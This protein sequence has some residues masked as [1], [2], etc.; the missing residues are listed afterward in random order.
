MQKLSCHLPLLPLQVCRGSTR[1]KVTI[2]WIWF[3]QIIS[4][5]DDSNVHSIDLAVPQNSQSSPFYV[6]LSLSAVL[7]SQY[8][9]FPSPNFYSRK[10]NSWLLIMH[11]LLANYLSGYLWIDCMDG[12]FSQVV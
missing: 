9:T 6:Q 8:F 7:A 5:L 1:M 2:F 11:L 10:M 4:R 3:S 12:P